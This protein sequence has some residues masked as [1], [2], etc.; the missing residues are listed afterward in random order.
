VES[1]PN[2]DDMQFIALA[3]RS[4]NVVAPVK[5]KRDKDIEEQIQKVRNR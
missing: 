2:E 5:K 4:C 3:R 1:E